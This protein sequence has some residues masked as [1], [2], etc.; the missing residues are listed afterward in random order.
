MNNCK[1][2]QKRSLMSCFIYFYCSKYGY[3]M[4]KFVVFSLLLLSFTA[5]SQLISDFLLIEGRYRSFHYNKPAESFNKGS[6]VFILHGSGGNGKGFMR[7]TV[8]LEAI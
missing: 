4:K 7:N 6:L 8:Q 2:M 5:N 3:F 1:L